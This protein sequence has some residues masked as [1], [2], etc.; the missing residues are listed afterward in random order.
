LRLTLSAREDWL[1]TNTSGTRVSN[2][3]FTYRAGLNYVFNSGLAPYVSYAT[4]FLPNT[5][6]D[7]NGT[8]FVPSTGSQIEGGVKFEPKFVPHDVKIFTTAAVYDLTEQH[9]LT[10]DPNPAHAF[11]YVQTGE[12]EVKGVE[13]EAVARIRERLTLNGDYTYTDSEVT[14]SNGPDLGKQLPTVPRNKASLLVD[15]TE[16]TGPLAG[17]GGGVGLR[18]IGQLYGDPANT[19]PSKAVT[20]V[21]AIVHFDFRKWRVSVNASNLFDKIYIQHCDSDVACFYAERR[22]VFLTVGRKF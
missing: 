4:S 2:S 3:A 15:Y 16:Q 21:D 13:L 5:G 19:I 12:V 1:E 7:F 18:Y 8:P 10:N 14:K 11:F 9:V 22:T 20:L 6:A 17:L